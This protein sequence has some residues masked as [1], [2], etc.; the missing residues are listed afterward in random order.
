M[1]TDWDP[2]IKAKQSVQK[3]R[4]CMLQS[5]GSNGLKINIKQLIHG[6]LKFLLEKSVSLKMEEMGIRG[7]N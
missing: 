3:G 6:S 7:K 1:Q 4:F 2:Y 5:K